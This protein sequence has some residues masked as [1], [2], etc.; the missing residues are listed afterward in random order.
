MGL[1]GIWHRSICGYASHAVLPYDQRL[2]RF[3][4]HLQQLDM[5]SLGKRVTLDGKPITRASG[6]VVWGEPG[7]NG[8]HAFFQLL[9]QGSDIVP[10]DFLFA[11]EG[12][13]GLPVHHDLLVA[14]A[15]AQTQALMR[16]RTEA[17][18]LAQLLA[19]GM[20]K[21]E[22]ERLAP[23]RVFEGNRPSVTFLYPRLDPFTLGAL[24]ALY[25]HKVFVMAAIWGINAFDQWGV[26]LGKELALALE[27]AL[28]GK[29]VEGLD[30][31]TEGLLA[32]LKAMRT[33]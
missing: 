29:A 8:Q 32:T 3:A 28:K 14:N 15:L 31:S 2:A 12:H 18:A 20:D 27:P 30:G 24:I 22:A 33:A 21:A 10:A 16:G 19:K 11:A 26:E 4:A 6:P 17:E 5:E 13:D 23:H 25:E 1:L 9:H 7:T